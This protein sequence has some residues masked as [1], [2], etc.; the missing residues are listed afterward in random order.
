MSNKHPTPDATP[1]VD[2]ADVDLDIESNLE[3]LDDEPVPPL[4]LPEPAAPETPNTDVDTAPAPAYRISGTATLLK[5]PKSPSRPENV[6]KYPLYLLNVTATE[7]EQ[8]AKQYPNYMVTD[9]EEG[10]NWVEA[11]QYA[12]HH[13]FDDDAFVSTLKRDPAAWQQKIDYE[14]TS[15]GIGRPGVAKG[16][17][18]TNYTGAAG[19]NLIQSMKGLGQMVIVPLWHTGIWV[20]FTA[21]SDAELFILERQLADAKITMGRET[22]G[23]IYSG[24]SVLISEAVVDFALAH[25][26]DANIQDFNTDKLMQV[27]SIHDL[28]TIAWALACTVYPNGYPFS[29][30]CVEQPDKCMHVTNAHLAVDKLSWTDQSA[31]TAKQREFMNSRKTKHTVKE[32]LAYQAEMVRFES[33]MVDLGDDISML[34]KVPSIKQFLDSGNRWVNTILQATQEAFGDTLSN[35]RRNGYIDNQAQLAQIRQYAHWIGKVVVTG[36]GVITDQTTLE[37]TLTTLSSD[38]ELTTKILKEIGKYIDGSAVSVIAIP[39]Y[40]CPNCQKPLSEAESQHPFLV[41][42]DATKV[43]FTLRTLRL[44]RGSKPEIA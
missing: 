11:V 16:D 18:Q 35:E 20:T 41:P 40:N 38:P 12:A 13:S 21:P 23:L 22:A 28:Q 17:G 36:R 5:S 24:T 25:V 8:K 26:F 4:E 2:P 42:L 32:I 19:V 31:L 39:N 27:L 1:L 9:S 44:T 43:F 6:G 15:L 7:L 14:G 34:L 10:K 33:A 29:Q 37:N 30:P 3:V